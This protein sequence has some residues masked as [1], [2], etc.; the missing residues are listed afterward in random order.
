[1]D[2]AAGETLIGRSAACHV[3]IEDPLVSRQ[4]ARVVVAGEEAF[5]EDLGSR[6]GVRLNGNLIQGRSPIHDGDRLRIGTQEMVVCRAETSPLAQA[7]ATGV[8]RL[9]A[10]C[11]LPYPREVLACPHCGVTEQTDED[12]LSGSMGQVQQ[13][14]WSLQLLVEAL[15]RA[16]RLGR[17]TDAHRILERATN[18]IEEMMSTDQDFAH[19]QVTAVAV[20][21]LRVSIVSKD[22]TWGRWVLRLYR[23]RGILPPKEVTDAI[24]ELVRE[25]GDDLSVELA[26]LCE[27]LRKRL[28]AASA[29]TDVLSRFE[30]ELQCRASG[31][32]ERVGGG[33]HPKDA[34]V[35]S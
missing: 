1:M 16:I 25:S 28:G 13:R 32:G 7:R 26:G 8:L 19:E 20:G 5:V 14:A 18:Q 10:G 4:H 9:C 24:L 35:P 2:L 21:G 27:D 22:P 12:T 17:S 31:S 3:T 11:K 23:G 34:A 15:D 30:E 6:N 29:T 33:A